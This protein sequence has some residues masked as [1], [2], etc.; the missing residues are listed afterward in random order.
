MSLSVPV[1]SPVQERSPAASV[2]SFERRIFLLLAV[3]ALLYAFL[4]GLRAVSDFDL[5][6]QM[7]TG[8][9][10]VQHHHIPSVDV[11]SYTAQG[12]P[13]VYPVGSGLL[14]YLAYLAGSYGL[15]SWIG[16]LACVLTVGLL[17]RRGSAVTAAI[18]ILA[19]PLIAWRT[20]PR[21]DM[22]TLVLFA[23]FLSLLWENYQTGRARLWLLPLLM[24]AWVNLHPGFVAGLGLVGAYACAELLET[25]FAE[26][27]RA[28][29]Q[30]LRRASGWLVG[31]GLATLVNPWGWGI[32]QALMRQQR[33]MGQ[34]QAWITEWNSVPMSWG[35]VSS[36]L[37]PRQTEGTIYLL[38]AVAVVAAVIS[39]LRAQLGAALWLLGAIY[40]AV[41]YVR[42]GALFACVAAVVG[43][44]VLSRELSRDWVRSMR[45]RSAVAW[46]AVLA[47][48]LLASVRCFDL[49]TNRH[50]FRGVDETT[51]GAGLSW[52]FPQGATEFIEREKLPG[53]VF[54]TYDEGGYFTWRL[55]A[56]R[57]DYIDGRAL[58]FGVALLQRSDQLLQDSPDSALWQQETSRYNLNT[59][60]LPLGRYDGVQLVR[61]QDFCNS[62]L[63]RPVYLDEVSAVFV[64]RTPETEG[65][66]Q[67]FPVDCATA[68]LPVRPP[69]GG[70]AD[71]FNA[72]A[73]AASV[74]A[75]LGRNPEALT[76]T[77]KALSIFPGSAFL[78]WQRANLLFAMGQLG[79]SEQEYL[80]AI[81]IEPSEV[82]W[83][84]LAESY[85]KRGRMPAAVEAMQHA[86]QLSA[87][88]HLVLVK[89]GYLYLSLRQPD[90]AVNAFDE[91]ARRTPWGFKPADNPTFAFMLAQ[92]RS[93]AWDALGDLEKATSYQEEAAQLEPDVP[94]PWR[95]LAKLYERDGRSQDA[96]RAREHA[97]ALATKQ[98]P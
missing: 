77:E 86:A 66:I 71:A 24:A 40:P 1:V 11:F 83:T 50:Y 27:R 2:S 30:R 52:W 19:I 89:L 79:D 61:L 18:A 23:A 95:R 39:L 12:Q 34:H 74:L 96:T 81:S 62:K 4:A 38:L 69:T 93:G 8:R 7:A 58:P 21:A 73:N 54:N 14:F 20:T 59:I 65:L 31:T 5:G 82:T 33:V 70:G 87:N 80:A 53:E 94:A 91:A 29:V 6:W 42:M 72:W 76:A 32:Y 17:L 46:A 67:R 75:A 13:W 56:E 3:L 55:G 97:E 36:I 43:G 84:A 64:R 88:P 49:V 9:W 57:R 68:P 22:F 98:R 92:G 51:F 45:A 26:S 85:Q 44:W 15:I 37:S 90:H 35:A 41:R 63:W 25:L 28:A 48:A 78:H 47:L 16:A 60:L 10:V